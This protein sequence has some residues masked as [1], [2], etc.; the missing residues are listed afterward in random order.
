[1]LKNLGLLLATL[2]AALVVF[3]IWFATNIEKIM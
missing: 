1:M 3:L 2:G